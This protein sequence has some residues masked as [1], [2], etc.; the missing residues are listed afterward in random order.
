MF[1]I[2]GVVQL[3]GTF[4]L[5]CI[6][7]ENE[8]LEIGAFWKASM[9]SLLASFWTWRVFV[10]FFQEFLVNQTALPKKI[11]EYTIDLV[12]FLASVRQTLEKKKSM[13]ELVQGLFAQVF[14]IVNMASESQFCV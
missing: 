10:S 12:I 13:P 14:N 3:I 4:L 6:I 2:E 1:D 11:L 7:S 5:R 8:I 9:I